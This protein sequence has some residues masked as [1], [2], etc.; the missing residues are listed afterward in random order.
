MS[1]RAPIPPHVLQGDL[2]LFSIQSQWESLRDWM[3]RQP[4]P[5]ALDLSGVEDLDLSGIQLL[6]ALQRQALAQGSELRLT[7]VKAA[8]VERFRPLGLAPFLEG[9]P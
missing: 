6:L 9:H 4:D 7:G 1:R 5:V 8:W 3:G 2:D